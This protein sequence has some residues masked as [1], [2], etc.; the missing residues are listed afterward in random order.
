M[1]RVLHTARLDLVLLEP[2]AA[3]ELA[4]GRHHDGEP[5]APA[6]RSDRACSAPS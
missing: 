5:W 1:G 6:T 2:K 4:A 3:R